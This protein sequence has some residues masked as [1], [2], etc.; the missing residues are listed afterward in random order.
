MYVCKT[1]EEIRERTEVWM[2]DYNEELPHDALNDLTPVEYRGLQHSE[3]SI[4]GWH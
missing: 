4:S 1:L 2:E 3:T